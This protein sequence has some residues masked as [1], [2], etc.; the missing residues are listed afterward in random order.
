MVVDSDPIG[1]IAGSFLGILKLIIVVFCDMRGSRGES[2]SL[3]AIKILAETM[4]LDMMYV[5]DRK[6]GM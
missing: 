3:M 1:E 6:A 2:P 5:Y 4:L